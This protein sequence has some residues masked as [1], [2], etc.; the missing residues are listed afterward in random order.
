MDKRIAEKLKTA[1][2]IAQSAEAVLVTPQMA[3]ELLESQHE[4]RR[5]RDGVSERYEREM[6]DGTFA[7][8][9]QGIAIDEDDETLVDG[10]H[11][12]FAIV[13]TGL[14]QPLIVFRVPRESQVYMDQGQIR[15]PEDIGVVMGHALTKRED[16]VARNMMMGGTSTK[17]PLRPAIAKFAVDHIEAIRFAVEATKGLKSYNVSA[18]A[19][20]A[21][22]Y[23]YE[24]QTRVKQYGAILA[25]GMARGDEDGAAHKFRMWLIENG[26]FRTSRMERYRKSEVALR[27]F[28]DRKPLSRIH[29]PAGATDLWPVP[30]V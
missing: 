8:T 12:L 1:K 9:H 27:A 29:V 30:T 15:T 20:M 2:R 21:R 16:G 5:L 3:E 25:G 22:A 17:N 14:A 28:I 26:G 10:Q 11:R 18:V 4:N 6:R 13:N 24:D 7:A 19:P 23:Y